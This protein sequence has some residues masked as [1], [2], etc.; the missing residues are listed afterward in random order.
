[1]VLVAC[2][3]ARHDHALATGR[4]A[5]PYELLPWTACISTHK[6]EPWTPGHVLHVLTRELQQEDVRQSTAL[7]PG[8][9]VVYV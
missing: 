3:L 2:I 1:M 6:K 9:C 5:Q 4:A 8:A 7:D